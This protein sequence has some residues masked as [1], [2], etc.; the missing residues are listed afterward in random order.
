LKQKEKLRK[1]EK[2]EAIS[3]RYREDVLK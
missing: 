3:K 1:R 2:K